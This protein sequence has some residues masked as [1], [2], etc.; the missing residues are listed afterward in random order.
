VRV[1]KNKPVQD[2]LQV[3]GVQSRKGAAEGAAP[4]GQML[5]EERGRADSRA[6]LNKLLEQITEQG[7]MIARRRDMG[8]IKKYRELVSDFLEEAMRSAYQTDKE[9]SFD[10]KGRYKEYSIV[11]KINGEVEKL[12]QQALE[13][14]RDNLAILGQ[15]GTIRGLL[16]D[17]MI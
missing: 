12:A 17:L 7:G 14:Q 4:F 6:V 11:R 16:I 1:D 10:A 2:V 3:Q 5:R 8:D 15:L 13:D 9:S